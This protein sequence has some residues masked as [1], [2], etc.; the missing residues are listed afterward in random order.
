MHLR[1]AGVDV[2]VRTPELLMKSH[3]LNT[4]LQHLLKPIGLKPYPAAFT[5]ITQNGC[6][7]V[8]EDINVA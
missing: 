8:I 5:V 6:C 4:I 3:E 7:V 1:I 2:T